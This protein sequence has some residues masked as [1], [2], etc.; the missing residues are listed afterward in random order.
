MIDVHRSRLTPAC[1]W[2]EGTI[3]LRVRAIDVARAAAL[4]LSAGTGRSLPRRVMHATA[5]ALEIL[6]HLRSDY[7]GDRL[8]TIGL[9]GL[10]ATARAEVVQRLGVGLARVV[11]ERSTLGLVD[12]YNLDA[13]AS[14][15]SAPVRIVRHVPRSRRRPDFAGCDASGAWSLLEA[16]GRMQKGNLRRDRADAVAQ[17]RAIDLVRRDGAPMTVAHRIA[18][19]SRLSTRPIAV[20]ADDPPPEELL[21]TVVIDPL[22]L[23]GAYYELPRQ[24]V[25]QGGAR[26]PGISGAETFIGVAL[27]GDELMLGIHRALI[28]A[29][30]EPEQLVAIRAQLQE[31]F[32]QQQAEAEEAEDVQLS[33]GRDGLA[34]VSRGSGAIESVLY[35]QQ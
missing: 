15:P 8:H 2:P 17:V 29:L 13:L 19:V 21:R 24:I 31:E 18:C 1:A 9:S 12:F 6:A 30:D 25:A 7:R 20:F 11:A 4:T 10:D 3:G 27:L 33:V 5:V 14:D 34:L 16:K 23:I 28:P 22:E 35:G 26:G 32:S